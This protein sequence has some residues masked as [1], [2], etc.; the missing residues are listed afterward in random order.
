MHSREFPLWRRIALF[1]LAPIV[2]PISIVAVVAILLPVMI[3]NALVMLGYWI[4]N[5]L[6]GAPIPPKGP[7]LDQ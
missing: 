7:R 6:T 5:K 4:R 2:L 1:V 3:W